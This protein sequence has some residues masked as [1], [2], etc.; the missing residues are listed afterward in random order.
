MKERWNFSP[1]E[2][3]RLTQDR[4][5]FFSAAIG[6]YDNRAKAVLYLDSPDGARFSAATFP[7]IERATTQLIV[8]LLERLLCD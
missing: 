1:E 3:S 4:R 6:K 7:D 5:S 2:F 8:P